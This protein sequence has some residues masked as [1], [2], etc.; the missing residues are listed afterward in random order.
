MNDQVTTRPANQSAAATG[1]ESREAQSFL[2]PPVDIYEDAD[3]ISLLL[4]MP[5]VSRDRVKIDADRQTLTIEGTVQ[6]PMPDAMEALYAEVHST[7]YRRSFALSGELD[8][9]RIEASLADGVLTLRIPRR[10]E[11]RPRKIEVRAG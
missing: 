1:G 4:D 3:G 8:P 9:D 5:G 7:Q 10:A 2:R 6:I 11:L